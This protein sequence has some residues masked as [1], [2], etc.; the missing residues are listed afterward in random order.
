[1][2]VISLATDEAVPVSVLSKLQKA[3]NP[4]PAIS[5]PVGSRLLR[6]TRK[7]MGVED[8]VHEPECN[9]QELAFGIPWTVED[10]IA[11]AVQ[12]KQPMDILEFYR[13]R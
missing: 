7:I 4:D 10:H 11:A 3:W 8:G 13:N 9:V 2:Q 5:L 1:M 6:C 12:A